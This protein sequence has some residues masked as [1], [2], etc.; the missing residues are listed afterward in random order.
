MMI[1]HSIR[2]GVTILQMQ[3]DPAN[4]LDVE[5]SDAIQAAISAAGKDDQ[6]KAVVLTGAESV[7]SAG[8]DLF[9]LLDGGTEYV[10]AFL[11]SLNRL[12][13]TAHTTEKP[14]VAAINGHA[15]A[16]G[17]ILAL[18][19]DY[20][21]M[22]DGSSTIGLPE[23]NV[24]VPFPSSALA[25]VTSSVP[26]Q[27]QREVIL[28]GRSFDPEAAKARG[29]IDEIAPQDAVL[30]RSVA[31]ARE[32]ASVPPRSFS[33]TKRLLGMPPGADTSDLDEEVYAT[34]TDPATHEHIRG[35]LE[36]TL[37]KRDR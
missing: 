10:S 27:Y 16:G 1:D 4:V 29:L 11:A 9:R 7:F 15:I 37:G 26:R 36:K 3:R 20:R 35:F 17:A 31:I 25:I 12:F 14:L 5:F 22:A 13:H 30:N 2:D 32:L 28:L 24:G 19:C 21:V 18:A 8:V 23:L 6:T 33:L 34:W